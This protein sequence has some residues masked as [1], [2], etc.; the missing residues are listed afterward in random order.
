MLKRGIVGFKDKETGST[1]RAVRCRSNEAFQQSI[2]SRWIR[3]FGESLSNEK[4][5][6][7]LVRKE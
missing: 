1:V 3:C 4:S 5:A 6:Q 2:H 7:Q